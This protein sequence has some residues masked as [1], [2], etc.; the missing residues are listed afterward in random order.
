ML[1]LEIEDKKKKLKEKK[2]KTCFILKTKKPFTLDVASK[3]FKEQE[4]ENFEDGI[5]VMQP[6]Y[7]A[8]WF[9]ENIEEIKFSLDNLDFLNK[10]K[11]LEDFEA[12]MHKKVTKKSLKIVSLKKHKL[13][14]CQLIED[15]YFDYY[16]TINYD[17]HNKEE[18]IKIDKEYKKAE[19]YLKPY[20]KVYHKI[21]D[22]L[23]ERK[24]RKERKKFNK[25]FY[26]QFFIDLGYYGEGTWEA[27]IPTLLFE[28]QNTIFTNE[29]KK[30]LHDSM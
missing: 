18:R 23:S 24:F 9:L 5:R 22:T 3:F 27:L 20:Y 4:Y 8:K 25:N 1:A 10:D 16:K 2:E 11:E 12:K 7:I 30:Y 17:T 15:K 26:Y 28:N 21:M 13:E 19:T 29:F 6:E 14:E